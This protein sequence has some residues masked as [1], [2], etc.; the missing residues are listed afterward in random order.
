MSLP[1]A[2]TCVVVSAVA[3]GAATAPTAIA[4]CPSPSARRLRL[5][6]L[7]LLRRRCHLV[8]QAMERL[9]ELRLR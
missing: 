3:M 2:I 7:T 1:S 4:G 6:T 5:R 9:A 8:V